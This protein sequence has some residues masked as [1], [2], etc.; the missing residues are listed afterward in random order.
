[1]LKLVKI[2]LYL[3]LVGTA[4][5][6]IYHTAPGTYQRVLEMALGPGALLAHLVTAIG[7]VMGLLVLVRVPEKQTRI[8]RIN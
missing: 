8:K 1:M 3:I 7:M 6:L 5:E 2:G 4:L